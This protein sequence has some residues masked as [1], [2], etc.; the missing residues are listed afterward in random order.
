[1]R[2]S[3][4]STLAG[5]AAAVLGLAVVGS[6]QG[7][8]VDPGLCKQDAS[9][10]RATIL[11]DFGASACFGGSQLVLKD[12]TNLV[13]EVS[14]SGDVRAPSRNEGDSGLAADATRLKSHGDPNIFLPDDK[15]FFPV[16]PGAGSVGIRG[17]SENGFYAIATTIADFFPGKTSGIVSA[18]TTFTTKVNDD[19]DNYRTCLNGKNWFAQLGC[20]VTLIGDLDRTVAEGTLNGG[21]AVA[22]GV[23]T[24]VVGA[25]LSASTWSK[26]VSATV[27][28]AK[29]SLHES[30]TIKFA[31]ALAKPVQPPPTSTAQPPP[32]TT[33]QPTAPPST[34]TSPAESGSA[35][36]C[37]EFEQMDGQLKIQAIQQMQA[38]HHDTTGFRLALVSVAAFCS[39]YPEHTIDGVYNGGL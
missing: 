5:T 20:R 28:D 17:S 27:A 36:T 4:K 10:P 34:S 32:P 31:A 2:L 25:I 18:F 7:K 8:G 11:P 22:K 23:A 30:G 6:A 29:A 26:W 24:G 15:L 9:T 33:S 21:L 37:T 39:V 38:Q 12:A 19:F 35:P 13:L 14:R 16:G 1:M 3:Y